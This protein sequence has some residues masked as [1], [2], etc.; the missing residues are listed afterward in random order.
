MINVNVS[1]H[2]KLSMSISVTATLNLLKEVV[3]N[4]VSRWVS[5][6]LLTDI[7]KTEEN[8]FKANAIKENLTNLTDFLGTT[9]KYGDKVVFCD[10]GESRKC[11]EHGTVVGFTNKRIYVVHGD[12]NSEIL[13]DSRDVVLNYYFMN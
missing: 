2:R 3:P 1:K 5:K 11:L 9:L 4:E 12:R 8:S 13:K 6:E 10:P 7:D